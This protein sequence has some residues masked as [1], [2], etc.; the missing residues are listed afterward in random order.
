MWITLVT[1]IGVA[2]DWQPQIDRL[3]NPRA[4]ISVNSWVTTWSL[5]FPRGPTRN[6]TPMSTGDVAFYFLSEV[7]VVGA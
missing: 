3:P 6:T 7:S 1:R 5:K 4:P 2:V